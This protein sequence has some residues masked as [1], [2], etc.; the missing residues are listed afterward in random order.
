M[1]TVYGI[2]ALAAALTFLI[3]ITL[4][5]LVKTKSAQ[6]DLRAIMDGVIEINKQKDDLSKILNTIN[7]LATGVAGKDDNEKVDNLDDDDS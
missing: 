2:Y 1:I 6:E 7:K 5:I 3:I 4:S